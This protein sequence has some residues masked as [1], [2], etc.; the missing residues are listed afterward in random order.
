MLVSALKCFIGIHKF[1]R[2]GADMPSS[3]QLSMALNSWELMNPDKTFKRRN[4]RVKRE[5][6]EFKG[7]KFRGSAPVFR[8]G[9]MGDPIMWGLDQDGF[10]TARMGHT[11]SGGHS[12]GP[13]SVGPVTPGGQAGPLSV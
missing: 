12:N 9:E 2:A 4:K 10:S 7:S 6:K 1:P 11:E 8:K 13:A 5:A 3:N